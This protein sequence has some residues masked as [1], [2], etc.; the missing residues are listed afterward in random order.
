MKETEISQLGEFGL[1]DKLTKNLPLVNQQTVKGVGD[2][3]AVLDFNNKEVLVTT[4]LLLEG[5]HFDLRYVPLKHLGY[6]AAV[7]NFSDVYAMNGTPK[8]ITVSLGISSRFTIE[9]I[10]EL[11]SGI[12]LACEIYGVDLVGGDTSAS[13]TGLVIS[14][15]CI[16]EANKDDIVYRNGAKST[17]LIC[18]SGDLGAAFMG[19]QLL[20]RENKIAAGQKEGFQPDFSGK[21]Y[22]LERQLKPEARKDIIAMLR[23]NGIHPTS[24]MDVSDGLSSEL[25]HLCKASDTGCR[26]YEEKIPIDYQTAVMAEEFNMNLVTAAM[27]GGE[28]YELVFTVPLTDKD[29]IE[30]LKGVSMI[31]YMTKPELGCALVC[32]DGQEF[33]IKAQGWNAFKE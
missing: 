5:I 1:I 11:Y 19:L 7:V 28:D 24:M 16:G 14:V 12:R 17:D 18:V 2:D 29:K 21:E 6:K 25:L 13:V 8:Q 4:D 27:N 23:E 31:G 10:E 30:R 33:P 3:A 32:P 15:T 22:I 9:H 20:E 26:I